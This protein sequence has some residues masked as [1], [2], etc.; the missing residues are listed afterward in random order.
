MILPGILSLVLCLWP[1][2]P[3]GRWCTVSAAGPSVPDRTVASVTAE[4]G[5]A[6]ER[7]RAVFPDLPRTPFRIVLHRDAGDLPPVL[8]PFHHEGSPG[9]ALLGRHEIHLLVEAADGAPAGLR[10]VLVHELVH[11]FLDQANERLGVRLP[12]WFHEGLAQVIA[13]DTYLGVSEE[14][15]VWRAAT[16]QLLP[17]YELAD[18]FPRDPLLLRIAYAQSYSFVAWLERRLGRADLIELARSVDKDKSIELALVHATGR[19]T[20]ALQDEWRD[21]VL[22]GSGASWRV[23]LQQFFALSMVLALPL[24]AL[25]MIRRQRADRLARERLQDAET[26]EAPMPE[27]DLLP[28]D[29]DPDE[30]ERDGDPPDDD[31]TAPDQEERGDGDRPG[32]PPATPDRPDSRQQF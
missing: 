6:M 29:G 24:L 4:V 15:I 27:A 12:R 26:A 14:L 21:H 16:Q 20:A 7:V 23:L 5:P 25:A 11:E 2:D 10:A 28:E 3:V 32:D 17:F 13:G 22:H 30:F 31:A 18:G 1:Q 19:S 9:F 8:R